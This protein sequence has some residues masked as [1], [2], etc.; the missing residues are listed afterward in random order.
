MRDFIIIALVIPGSLAALRR[1][2]IGIMVWTW[3]SIMNPHRY[4]YGMAYSAPLAAIVAA[5]TLVGLFMTRERE[6]PFK[7]GAVT[8]FS[9]FIF[10]FTLSWLFGLDLE[11]DYEQWKKVIKID[12]MILVA[13]ALLHN[14]Q[15][16]FAL[17]WVC[18][19]S[20][21]PLGLK[22]GLFTVMTGGSLHV[23]GPPGS[24]IET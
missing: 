23:Y 5:C 18:V 20:L 12:F 15:H 7:G 24:F 21:A 22:G 19:G 9:L 2:W 3:L 6:S 16:I 11:G 1:P 14:K 13:L 8:A 4:T 17:M 10:W